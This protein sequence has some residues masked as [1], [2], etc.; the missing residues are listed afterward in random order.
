[1]ARGGLWVALAGGAALLVGPQE[2]VYYSGI[3]N[4]F[5]LGMGLI[6]PLGT[7]I[8]LQPFGHQA[9]AASALLG[10]LQMSAPLSL[11][12]WLPCFHCRFI[13]RSA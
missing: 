3:V 9:G 4:V 11:F 8:T 13:R 6:N 5:L 10:F 7:A 1:M 2:V 12:A